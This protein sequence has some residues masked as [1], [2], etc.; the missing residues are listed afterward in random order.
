MPEYI[1]LRRIR[2]GVQHKATGLTRHFVGGGLL[3]K[4]SELL[5]VRYPDDAGYY[6]LYCDEN[7]S[8]LTDTFHESLESAL[9]QAEWEFQVKPGEWEA[10]T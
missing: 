1:V 8:E 5:V 9:A 3:S 6:L 10:E 4:P 2:L 7:G